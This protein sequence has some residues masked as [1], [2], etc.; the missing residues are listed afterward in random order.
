L[1]LF[2]EQDEMRIL[3][4]IGVLILVVFSSQAFCQILEIHYINVGQG[5]S[6][7][8]V[9]PTGTTILIDA[10]NSGYLSLLIIITT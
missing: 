3:M 5:D 8:I 6:T 4:A 10:G 9:G 7:L 1:F 2:L